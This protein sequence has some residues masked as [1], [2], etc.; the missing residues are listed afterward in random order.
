M[1]RGCPP[2]LR[3]LVFAYQPRDTAEV[4]RRLMRAGA[5]VVGKTDLDQF[6]TGSGGARAHLTGCRRPPSAPNMSSGLQFGVGGGGCAG[7]GA[8]CAGYRH[9]RVRSGACR[10]STTFVGLS[11]RPERVPPHG[12]F[13]A[14]R[15][16]DCVSVFNL[17]TGDAARG[18]ERHRRPDAG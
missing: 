13:P 7:R 8:V 5:I 12:V 15:T 18:A 14:C 11:R 3:A 10:V 16:L 4:V 2:Q 9:S 1:W 6:A 17:T